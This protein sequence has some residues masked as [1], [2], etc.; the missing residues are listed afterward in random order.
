MSVLAEALARHQPQDAAETD[1]LAQIR[2]FVARH[3]EPF[4]RRIL[5]GQSRLVDPQTGL[6]SAIRGW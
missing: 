6:F 4:D 5:E 1:D 3:P 2:G